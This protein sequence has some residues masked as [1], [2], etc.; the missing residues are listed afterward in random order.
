MICSKEK[1][2]GC[3][4][5]FNICPKKCIDMKEDEWGYIYPDIDESICINCNLCK[6]ACPS[7]E[8]K[9]KFRLPEKTFVS[10]SIDE[11][12]RLSSSSGGAASVISKYIVET[13]GYVFGAAYDK[14]LLV[15]H[16]GV[17]TKE[18]LSKLKESK[19]THSSIGASFS[20]VKSLLIDNKKVL[21]IGTPCQ[22]A[23]LLQ[24]L[25]KGYDNLIT[26]DI[27][28]HGVP[29]NKMLVD[30]VQEI[31]GTTDID[32]VKFRNGTDNNFAI[33]FIKNNNVIYKKA[34]RESEYYMGF[35]EG[36][37]YRENCYTCSYAK[38]ERISDITLGDFWGIGK[39]EPFNYNTEKGVSL[40]LCNTEKGNELF[41]LVKDNMFVEERKLKEAV[42]GNEQL[43]KPTKHHEKRDIFL[44]KYLCGSFNKA[45]KSCLR[46]S[47]IKYKIK[48]I[49]RKV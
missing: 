24:F 46:I 42:D 48:R 19:Y 41:S 30:Y 43:R 32:K 31:L 8:T 25:D 49:L 45:I 16:I 6:K 12:D 26:I 13:G 10:W 5:C 20:E 3:Y 9:I 36:L 47:F 39:L 2:T 44:K 23:G 11:K 38:K 18:G 17:N 4:A 35:M 40:I 21:F 33:T 27:I 29:S 1:C 14:N 15:K 28:C 22:I 34:F 37:N 7:L